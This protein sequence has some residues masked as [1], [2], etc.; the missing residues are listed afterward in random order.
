VSQTSRIGL[1]L[2]LV[3]IVLSLQETANTN[4]DAACLW[5]AG[6]LALAG[7]VFLTWEGE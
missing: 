5:V 3:L 6:I 4:W 1:G 7:F 2:F